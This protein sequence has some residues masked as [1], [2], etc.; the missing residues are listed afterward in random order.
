FYR[1][2]NKQL[3][4]FIPWD[5]DGA[6]TATVR[7]VLENADQNVLMRRLMAIPEYKQY[8]FDALV[9]TATSAMADGWMQQEAAREYSQIQ[10]AAY[11]DPNKLYL[12]WGN[13]VPSSNAQ[14]DAAAAYVVA[15][16]PL[17]TQFVMTDIVT[18]GYQ[19]PSNYPKIADGGVVSAP[20]SV[21]PPARG[22]L[23]SIYGSN[24]GNG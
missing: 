20:S 16:A 5:K 18:Q 7:P 12:D 22:G 13:L 9:K 19:L 10:Q 6:F 24:L 1:F 8:Y 3:S 21:A 11:E 17:R 2:M 4:Q 15:F 23:A 14:F